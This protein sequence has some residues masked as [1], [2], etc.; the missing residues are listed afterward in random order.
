MSNTSRP[1]AMAHWRW[2][3]THTTGLARPGTEVIALPSLYFKTLLYVAQ[4]W[5]SLQ[6]HSHRY[7]PW[8]TINRTT[9][10]GRR[11]ETTE[12]AYA[13]ARTLTCLPRKLQQHLRR[14]QLSIEMEPTALNSRVTR[15]QRS[16]QQK[17]L[18]VQLSV[19]RNS[20]CLPPGE[21]ML[22][23]DL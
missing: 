20:S 11:T 23:E 5:E 7:L 13:K 21:E 10:R 1:H 12:T 17:V 4:S 2:C 8:R 19:I 14:S 15:H 3:L 9:R 18:P 16:V 6:P 22:L